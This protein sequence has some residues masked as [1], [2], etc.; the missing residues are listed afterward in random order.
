MLALGAA[1]LMVAVLS[2]LAVLAFLALAS[3]SL[4]FSALAPA[5]LALA[6]LSLA[7]SALA[8]LAFL[9]PASAALASPRAVAPVGGAT[10][11]VRARDARVGLGWRCRA[12][13]RHDSASLVAGQSGPPGT[14]RR[15]RPARPPGTA[16]RHPAAWPHWKA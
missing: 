16:A 4:A 15:G 5:C 9:A 14:R 1:A 10:R 2:A 6:S 8:V 11:V 3:L 7:F 13:V 12:R